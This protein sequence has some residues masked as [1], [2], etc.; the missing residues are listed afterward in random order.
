MKKKISITLAVAALA[1]TGLYKAGSIAK[2]KSDLDLNV[3]AINKA[4]GESP[5]TFSQ[6]CEPWDTSICSW[7]MPNG[8]IDIENG[9]R[10]TGGHL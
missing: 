1:A 10:P 7:V 3:L 8:G 6:Q 9:Y 4:S 5:G 2:S